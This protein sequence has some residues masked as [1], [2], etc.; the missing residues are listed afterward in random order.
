VTVR[1]SCNRPA[2]DVASCGRR[3]GGCRS[4]GAASC[5]P[6]R[7]VASAGRGGRSC[8]R[9]CVP[10]RN[11]WGR[12]GTAGHRPPSRSSR[13]RRRRRWSL[14]GRGAVGAGREAHGMP[15]GVGGVGTPRYLAS[16]RAFLH[17]PAHREPHRG[18]P[19]DAIRAI[20]SPLNRAESRIS[21]R[22]SPRR[23]RRG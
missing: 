4:A 17:M 21:S 19:Y 3:P 7:G 8:P 10:H 11:T 6:R 2:S 13:T 23:L 20:S 1:G 15:R 9:P 22:R 16:V 5:R 18:L 14:P 12:D